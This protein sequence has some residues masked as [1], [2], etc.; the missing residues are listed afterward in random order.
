MAI[1]YPRD[2]PSHTGIRNVELRAVSA[3]AYDMS[4]F[5]FGGTSYEYDGQMWQADLTL[6]PMRRADAE[7]WLAWL[8]SLRGRA[9]TFLLGDPLCATPRGTATSATLTGTTGSGTL[10]VTMTGTLLAGDYI[11]LGSASSATLHKVLEDQDGD[12]NLEIW[13]HLRRDVT[14]ESATLSNTVGVFRLASNEQAWSINEA[15]IYG[16]TF[17]AVEAI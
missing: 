14:A 6:P 3:T 11:Q 9:K 2:L 13:P 1:S 17:G 5:T 12:G 10:S 16:I 8:L 15:S 7:V 4:P